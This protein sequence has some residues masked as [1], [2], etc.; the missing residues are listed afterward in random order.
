GARPPPPPP[1]F[2]TRRSSDLQRPDLRPPRPPQPNVHARRPDHLPGPEVRRADRA[3][4]HL[5]VP[6]LPDRPKR[7][8]DPGGDHRV[9]LGL[10]ADRKSTRLNSSHV[11]ISY[12]V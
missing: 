12:A 3:G 8:D 1:S 7:F 2:P 11:K 10:V 5:P 4:A 6:L 9:R